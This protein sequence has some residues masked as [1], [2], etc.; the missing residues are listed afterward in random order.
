MRET[1]GQT[2]GAMRKSHPE[3]RYLRV[4]RGDELLEATDDL[5]LRGGDVIALGGSLDDLTSKM[6]IVGPEVPSKEALS[7][8]LDVADIL[9]TEQR[10][11]ENVA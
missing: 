3:Y 1:I 4:K 10:G 9:V 8:P 6:G 7:I 11:R 5:V 2:I